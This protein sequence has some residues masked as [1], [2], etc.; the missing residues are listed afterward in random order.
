M[1]LPKL[2][3]KREYKLKNISNSIIFNDGRSNLRIMEF[4]YPGLG[5]TTSFSCRQSDLA[6]ERHNLTLY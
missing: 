3:T 2:A 6:E 1:L 5:P 4:A